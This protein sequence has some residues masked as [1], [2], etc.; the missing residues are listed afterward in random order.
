MMRFVTWKT[1]FWGLLIINLL[2]FLAIFLFLRSMSI[3]ESELN[4]SELIRPTSGDVLLE[5]TS[6]KEQ[7]LQLI[8]STDLESEQDFVI[9][10]EGAYVKYQSSIRI[11]GQDIGF[12]V[13]LEPVVAGNGDL[14]LNVRQV[15]LGFFDIPVSMILAGMGEST[16]FPEWVVVDSGNELLHVQITEL[17]LGANYYLQFKEFDVQADNIKLELVAK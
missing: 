11:L 2:T 16:D 6:S 9:E 5:V 15:Q 3:D 8:Y 7:I 1:A 13:Y 4:R 10:F 14:L 17:D 12:T